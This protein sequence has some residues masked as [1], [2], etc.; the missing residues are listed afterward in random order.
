MKE[1]LK[2]LL[3]Q[4]ILTGI[5]YFIPIICMGGLLQSFGTI[6]GG[7]DVAEAAGTFA[8]YLYQGGSL[9]MNL[10]V[11]V[12]AAYISY[13]V[14][15][16]PGLAPGFLVGLLS[17]EYKIGFV[18]GIVGGLAVGYFCKL[19]KEKLPLSKDLASLLPMLIIPTLGG[20]FAVLF[21][22]YILG[23]VLGGLQS[24]LSTLFAQMQ[25]GSRV[26][27]GMVLGALMGV[28]LGGPVTKIGTTVVNGLV[29]D[30]ILGPEGAKVCIGVTAT[31]GIGISTIVSRRKYTAAQRATGK[32]AII[33]GCCQIAEGGLPILLADPLRVWPATI[34]GNMV[35]GAIAMYFNVQSPVMMGGLFA[36][37]VM[38]NVW[39]GAVLSVVAGTLTTIVILALVRKNVP[40]SEAS[41]RK[42]EAAATQAKPAPAPVLT[43]TAAQPAAAACAAGEDD[44]DISIEF[45]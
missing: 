5:S 11:P 20:L 37:P 30:G 9:T 12:L 21:M 25:S 14:C 34:I 15:D 17:I 43:Q 8:F 16:R 38:K 3:V 24:Y 4:P 19:I 23:P 18:G 45:E 39:P 13:S 1:K 7:A 10:V 32:S 41:P 36:F 6:L 27:F 44:L 22:D 28:D 29:A 35:T 42:A 33:L 40:E 2:A 31:L 26:V